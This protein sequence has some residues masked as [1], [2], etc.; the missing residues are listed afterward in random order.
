MKGEFATGLQGSIP[1]RKW[2]DIFDRDNRRVVRRF[3][4]GERWT[5]RWDYDPEKGPHVNLSIGS[6]D[7][8]RWAFLS[9]RGYMSASMLEDKFQDIV[10]DQSRAIGFHRNDSQTEKG[11]RAKEMVTYWVNRYFSPPPNWTAQIRR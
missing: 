9:N 3:H 11:R 6:G 10:R 1:P 5:I 2:L 4:S 7:A 8:M